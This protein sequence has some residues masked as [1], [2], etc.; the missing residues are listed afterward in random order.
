[1]IQPG[2]GPRFCPLAGHGFRRLN[3][4][5]A[6][7]LRFCLASAAD[8]KSVTTNA[9]RSEILIQRFLHLAISA[10]RIKVWKLT[11]AH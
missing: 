8:Q 3:S 4:D 11:D 9:R 10:Q 2:H 5:L 6:A 1:M 7:E